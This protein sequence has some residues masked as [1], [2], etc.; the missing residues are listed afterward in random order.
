MSAAQKPR[1][2]TSR[3]LAAAAKV[4]TRVIDGGQALDDALLSESERVAPEDR[5]AVQALAYGTIRWWPRLERIAALLLDRP[6][7]LAPPVRALIG[8]GLHQLEHSS[9]PA[10][11]MV[12]ESVEGARLI[13]A[14]RATGLVNAVLRRFL[15]EREQL[16]ARIGDDPVA[17]HAHPRW[18]IETLRGDWP[19]HWRTV[20]EENNRQAP[21]WLRVNRRRTSV[22]QYLDTLRAAGIDAARA[23]PTEA[24]GPGEA[25]DLLEVNGPAETGA[26]ADAIR[27]VEPC[28]VDELP[29]FADGLVSVQD[30]AAQLTAPLLDLRDGLRVLD[31]C[32]APGGKACQALEHAD[33]DLTAVD[34]AAERLETVRENLARL[35]LQAT[36][37]G[38]DATAPATWW[39]GRPFDRIL[40][41]A[42]C[43]ATGVI[44]RHPDI[45]LLRRPADLQSLARQ[46]D[47]LLRA[48]WPMLAPG[49]RLLYATCS[50][51][52]AENHEVVARFLAEEP[53]AGS[54]PV[55][56]VLGHVS[57]DAPGLQILPGEAGMDGFYYACLER[58]RN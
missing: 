37:L 33:V 21:M 11:A 34:A 8:V 57:P 56:A 28:D 13:G 4:A 12:D 30:C 40:I 58:R 25:S 7:A 26:L 46:Q 41:D 23:G 35:R 38:G 14:P 49:G 9:H 52:R 44:R 55:P 2:S 36:V 32:A 3:R 45:K 50:T 43:S 51:A 10:H 54:V 31:T 53:S 1:T 20:L 39:D 22:A 24:S 17:R 5:P 6:A 27:L 42:P 16:L 15:R 19:Q 18:L 47:A 48:A 29:G